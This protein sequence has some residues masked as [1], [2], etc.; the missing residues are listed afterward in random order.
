VSE[1]VELS[2]WVQDP[3]GT[4]TYRR[5]NEATNVELARRAAAG[6]DPADPWTGGTMRP[7][8]DVPPPVVAWVPMTMGDPTWWA[9]V[10]NPHAVIP[11]GG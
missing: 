5:Q 7:S 3:D 9:I 6:L 2:D 4:L 1:P 8:G 10:E 11:P